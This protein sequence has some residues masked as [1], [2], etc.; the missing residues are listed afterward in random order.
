LKGFDPR[1]AYAS[2]RPAL[3]RKRRCRQIYSGRR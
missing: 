2:L 1:A 3:R